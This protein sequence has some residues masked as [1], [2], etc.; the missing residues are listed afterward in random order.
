V[1]EEEDVEVREEEA[2]EVEEEV[3][4]ITNNMRI[5]KTVEKWNMYKN[6]P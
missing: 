5:E 3:E 6:N 2:T 1:K 4:V